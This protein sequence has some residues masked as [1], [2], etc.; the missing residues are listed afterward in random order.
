M[1]ARG[2]SRGGLEM[3][4]SHESP[5]RLELSLVHPIV[6][7]TVYSLRPSWLPRVGRI[8]KAGAFEGVDSTAIIALSRDCTA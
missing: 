1:A 7:V 3:V 6:Q 2:Q 8:P 4:S 5:H